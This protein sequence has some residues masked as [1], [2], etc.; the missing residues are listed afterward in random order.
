MNMLLFLLYCWFPVCL[1]LTLERRGTAWQIS[2]MA[3]GLSAEECQRRIF[4][5]AVSSFMSVPGSGV[6][7][8]FSQVTSSVPHKP[9]RRSWQRNVR[10]VHNRVS[11]NLRQE[12]APG[13]YNSFLNVS[14]WF[15]TWT[16]PNMPMPRALQMKVVTSVKSHVSHYV[17]YSDT[18]M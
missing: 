18:D 17:K 15:F 9:S 14:Q 2:E 10:L 8:D 16:A 4:R 6:T 3:N 13:Y 11:V 5:T 7:S 12:C 1:W